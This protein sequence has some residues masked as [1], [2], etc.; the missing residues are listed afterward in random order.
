MDSERMAMCRGGQRLG[1]R[2]HKPSKACKPR[3]LGEVEKN[4]P[5]ESLKGA[6]P[7]RPVD[8]RPLP[9]RTV[10]RINVR[11]FTARVWGNLS[12]QPLNTPHFLPSVLSLSWALL[13]ASLDFFPIKCTLFFFFFGVSTLCRDWGVVAPRHAPHSAAPPAGSRPWPCFGPRL[14]PCPL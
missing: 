4:D 7:R 5:L 11:G 2:G 6:E 3:K 14:S 10:K 13:Q 1:G 8:F 9:T 12:Q